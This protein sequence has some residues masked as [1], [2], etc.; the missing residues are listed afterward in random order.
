MENNTLKD[1]IDVVTHDT[2]E[3]FIGIKADGGDALVYFPLGYNLSEN[4]DEN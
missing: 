4:D 1:R 2:K 3:P